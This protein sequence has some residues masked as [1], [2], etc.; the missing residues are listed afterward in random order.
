MSSLGGSFLG[1]PPP[2]PEH[3]DLP[4][5]G[6]KQV[7]SIPFLL[8]RPS[9]SRVNQL[10]SCGRD[11]VAAADR[12]TKGF[13]SR[14][15]SSAPSSLGMPAGGVGMQD[16]TLQCSNRVASAV[17]YAKEWRRRV[18]DTRQHRGHAALKPKTFMFGS[19]PAP[20]PDGLGAAMGIAS[21]PQPPAPPPLREFPFP[22][23]R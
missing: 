3:R 12:L 5:P 21:F 14:R 22:G 6:Q 16:P 10:L 13:S 18:E 15:H 17:S 7:Q 8:P 23:L 19:A 4:V 9:Q 20:P 1:A 11:Q 2:K